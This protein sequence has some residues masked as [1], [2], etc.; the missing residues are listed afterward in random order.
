MFCAKP[1]ESVKS[2]R[3]QVRRPEW[4]R[5]CRCVCINGEHFTDGTGR[6]L[7]ES[8]FLL[9]L[10]PGRS[11]R[12][13]FSPFISA[14]ELLVSK[15]SFSEPCC[16]GHVVFSPSVL[17]VAPFKVRGR[18]PFVPVTGGGFGP[19]KLLASGHTAPLPV[20]K[21]APG[22]YLSGIDE[23]GVLGRICPLPWDG[24][25]GGTA[26]VNH[27]GSICSSAISVPHPATH[28]LLQ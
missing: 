20:Y 15:A 1:R 23:P 24:I 26:Q 17:S 3:A 28:V 11:P 8:A 12:S 10:F 16:S 19:A 5:P 9:C 18:C 14:T 6:P 21:L 4:R 22:S 2:L 27:L 7:P 13:F 25:L